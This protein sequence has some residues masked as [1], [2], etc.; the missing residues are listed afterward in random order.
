MGGH[1]RGGLEHEPALHVVQSI[2]RSRLREE[3]CIRANCRRPRILKAG[4]LH[5]PQNVETPALNFGVLIAKTL[6][7][8]PDFDFVPALDEPALRLE[9]VIGIEIDAP[10]ERIDVSKSAA[11]R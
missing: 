1:G 11:R 2:Q 3:V 8:Y 6:E 9:E 7:R 5:P 4:V 10:L